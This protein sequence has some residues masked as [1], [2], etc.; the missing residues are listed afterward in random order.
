[1]K[2]PECGEDLATGSLAVHRKTYHGVDAGWRQQWDTSPGQ[3]SPDVLDVVSNHSGPREC[4]V[5]GFRGRAEKRTVLRVNLLHIH[6]RETVIILEEGTPP[7][8]LVPLV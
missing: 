4:P 1:M 3:R 5:E 8:P 6:A 2:C 7:Q